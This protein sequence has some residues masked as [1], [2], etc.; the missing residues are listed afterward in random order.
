MNL[1]ESHMEKEIAVMNFSE[2]YYLEVFQEQT[3][4]KGICLSNIGVIMMQKGEYS[5]AATYLKVACEIQRDKLKG[6][7]NEYGLQQLR[8]DARA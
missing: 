4:H 3:D 6:D 1:A 2:L 8:D 7:Y 5:M